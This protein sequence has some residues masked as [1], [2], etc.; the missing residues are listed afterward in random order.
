M[1]TTL[2]QLRKS[3]MKMTK[4]VPLP[5]TF[6]VLNHPMPNPALDRRHPVRLHSPNDTTDMEPRYAF[7]RIPLPYVQPPF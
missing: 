2:G 4:F 3:F 6:R 1:P 5:D 7:V